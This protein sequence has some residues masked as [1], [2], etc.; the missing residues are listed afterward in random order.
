MGGARD[1]DELAETLVRRLGN[2]I[3]ADSSSYN[4]VNPAPA[5]G[6]LRDRHRADAHLPDASGIPLRSHA[7]QPAVVYAGTTRDG[8][9]HTWSDFTTGSRL[10]ATE[11]WNGLSHRRAP[12]SLHSR[13]RPAAGEKLWLSW[14]RWAS[15]RLSPRVRGHCLRHSATGKPGQLPID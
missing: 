4:E 5:A 11:L 9:A 12:S 10:H 15:R 8:T 3:P 7:R 1:L 6:I 14:V 13:A 2:A